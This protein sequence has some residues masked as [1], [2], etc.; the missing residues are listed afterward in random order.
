M[1]TQVKKKRAPYLKNVRLISHVERV[2][3]PCFNSTQCFVL[4]V[5]YYNKLRVREPGTAFGYKSGREQY[6]HQPRTLPGWLSF[7]KLLHVR[8]SNNSVT[9]HHFI[10]TQVRIFATKPFSSCDFVAIEASQLKWLMHDKNQHNDYCRWKILN[11]TRGG[12][13][14]CMCVLASSYQHELI[15]IEENRQAVKETFLLLRRWYIPTIM[16]KI[17]RL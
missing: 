8:L 10:V 7:K 17:S 6:Y 15:T 13:L 2:P 1:N 14:R 9:W 12:W 16:T 5:S 11:D 3:L 4:N